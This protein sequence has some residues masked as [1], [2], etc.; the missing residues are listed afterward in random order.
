MS[1]DPSIVVVRNEVQAD[2]EYHCDA[3]ASYFPGA[4]AVDFPAGER[5]DPDTVDG[6]VFSGSTAGVYEADDRPWIRDQERLVRELVDREVPTLGVCFGHQ[7]ANSALGGTVRH[8][9]MTA[10]LVEVEL[11]GDPLFAGVEPVVAASHGDVVTDAGEDMAVIASTDYY[12]AFGTRHRRAPLWTVQ[13]HPEFTGDIRD[14]LA[15]DFDWTETDYPFADV[16]APRVFENFR[17]LVTGPDEHVAH[18]S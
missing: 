14:Q 12:H 2:Y 10:R 4:R 6:V 1:T 5:F 9:G 17:S 8:E 13:F 3:L 18:R 11:A 7:V 16:N 15:E